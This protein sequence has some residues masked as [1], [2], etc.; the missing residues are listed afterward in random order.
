MK[1]FTFDEF[2][3]GV[4]EAYEKY[5]KQNGYEWNEPLGVDHDDEWYHIEFVRKGVWTIQIHWYKGYGFELTEQFDS[6]ESIPAEYGDMHE[7]KD[8][9][10]W[11]QVPMFIYGTYKR[12]ADA[13]KSLVKGDSFDLRPYKSLYY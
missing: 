10:E 13:L 5:M 6:L 4:R 9:P 1:E 2:Y 11:V 8:N 12:F 7:H 3:K